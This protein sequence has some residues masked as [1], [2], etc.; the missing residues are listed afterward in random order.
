MMLPAS[1]LANLLLYVDAH[2][3]LLR[4][5]RRVCLCRDEWLSVARSD[6]P[7]SLPAR[8]ALADYQEAQEARGRA[9]TAAADV[10]LCLP[11]LPSLALGACA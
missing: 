11:G 1:L 4:A 10:A 6:G 8:A 9:F 3:E 2:A 5:N 7:L